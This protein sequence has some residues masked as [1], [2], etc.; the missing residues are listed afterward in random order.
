MLMLVR[1]T[2]VW[3]ELLPLGRADEGAVGQ[4][5]CE[6]AGVVLGVPAVAHEGGGGC[7]GSEQLLGG[8][9][10]DGCHQR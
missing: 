1:I 9:G 2:Q 5:R 3:R 10:F 4:S 7:C 8:L 6:V